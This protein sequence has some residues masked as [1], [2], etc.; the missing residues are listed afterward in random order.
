MAGVRDTLPVR[1]GPG[2]D[3]QRC[4]RLDADLGAMG[5]ERIGRG[6]V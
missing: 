2:H 4:V 3:V 5:P 6:A 1:S